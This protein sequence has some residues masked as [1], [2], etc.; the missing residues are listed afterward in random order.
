MPEHQGLPAEGVAEALFGTED[1]CDQTC[2]QTGSVQQRAP[3]ERGPELHF[4]WWRGS[5]PSERF[6][7]L[8]PNPPQNDNSRPKAAIV[9]LVAGVGFEPTTFGL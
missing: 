9:S 2:E 6:A 3:P 7:L 4:R 8:L 1:S 5:E